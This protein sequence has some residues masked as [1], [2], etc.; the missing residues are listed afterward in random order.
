[1]VATVPPGTVPGERDTYAT[2]SAGPV[3]RTGA[4]RATPTRPAAVTGSETIRLLSG[5]G[6]PIGLSAQP[7]SELS[8]VTRARVIVGA[9]P[10][11]GIVIERSEE[12]RVGKECRLRMCQ[13]LYCRNSSRLCYAKLV[14]S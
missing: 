4:T 12:R 9:T 6:G 2:S 7:P 3:A 13:D 1:M 14:R 10:G 5:C 11:P 8:A